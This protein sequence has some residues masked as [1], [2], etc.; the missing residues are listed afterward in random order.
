MRLVPPDEHRG[1][2]DRARDET[3]EEC[4]AMLVIAAPC[5]PGRT[6]NAGPRPR[7]GE[8]DPPGGVVV[9]ILFLTNPDGDIILDVPTCEG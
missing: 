9:L 4:L 8:N 5:A 2:T 6:R 3:A 7:R 1:A